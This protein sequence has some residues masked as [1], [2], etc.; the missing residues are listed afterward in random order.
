MRLLLVRHPGTVATR[1]ARVPCDEPATGSLP[2]MSG[3]LGRTGTIVTSPARRCQVAGA[4]TDPLLGPWDLGRWA[5]LP[6]AAVPDLATW[7]TDPTY[8]GHGGESLLSLLDR[9]RLVLE[10]WH[11]GSGRT[12]AVTHGA[13]VRAAL[14]GVLQAPPESFW[15]IDVGPG[16]VTELH[17]IGLRWRVIRVNV[18]TS[19]T[20]Q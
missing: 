14:V 7:R 5:G 10:R 1:R 13:V 19:G 17:S 11:D 16:A 18:G 8:D 9:A 2:D 3:W 12:A 6:L 4:P 15:D 20:S